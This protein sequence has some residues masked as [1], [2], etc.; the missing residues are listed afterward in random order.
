MAGASLL[1]A[2]STRADA[3]AHNSSMMNPPWTAGMSSTQSRV[4]KQRMSPLQNHQL[5]LNK[6]AHGR[7]RAKAH[8]EIFQSMMIPKT[9]A[10]S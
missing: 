6:M 3:F 9:A 8:P 7:M 4:P 1:T 2:G 10:G 5:Y